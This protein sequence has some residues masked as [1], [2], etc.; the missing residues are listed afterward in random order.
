M[1]ASIHR[2]FKQGGA[3]DTALSYLLITLVSASAVPVVL[4]VAAALCG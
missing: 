3:V 4:A 2:V 1:I